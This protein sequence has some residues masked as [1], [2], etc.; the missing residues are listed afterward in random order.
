MYGKLPQVPAVPVLREGAMTRMIIK[1]PEGLTLDE[2][3]FQHKK[4]YQYEDGDGP[5]YTETPN[6]ENPDDAIDVFDDE[7]EVWVDGKLRDVGYIAELYQLRAYLAKFNPTELEQKFGITEANKE[8]YR[9]ISG[10]EAP[11]D[12]VYE[13]RAW[14]KLYERWITL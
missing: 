9:S 12:G 4:I 13:P 1:V 3:G 7:T 8:T 11:L 5:Y 6:S 2:L 14:L 10:T